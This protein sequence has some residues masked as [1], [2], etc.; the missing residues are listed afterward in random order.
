M[1]RMVIGA[2]A[3]GAARPVHR[4]DGPSP[5]AQHPLHRVPNPLSDFALG[6]GEIISIAHSGTDGSAGFSGLGPDLWTWDLL[7]GN[8]YRPGTVTG[9][10]LS[11]GQLDCVGFDNGT[12]QGLQRPPAQPV[13][14]AGAGISLE[15]GLP[16]AAHGDLMRRKPVADWTMDELKEIRKPVRQAL[17]ERD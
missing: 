11:G 13:V 7:S 12:G 10:L 2:A 14:Q 8:L 1:R 4:L 6:P 17:S 16:A 5:A 3:S 9:N 15:E